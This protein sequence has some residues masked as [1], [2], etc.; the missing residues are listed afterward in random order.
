[1]CLPRKELPELG[2]LREVF[3]YHVGAGLLYWKKRPHP[4]AR[5]IKSG[6]IAGT[7]GNSNGYVC[8]TLDKQ[9]YVAH[10][11]ENNYNKTPISIH[12]GIC[13]YKS[14]KKWHVRYRKKHIGYFKEFSEAEE[15][16]SVIKNAS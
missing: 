7:K 5:S 10:R 9:L 4:N 2:R 11:S 14:S 12:P 15:A 6:S 1:M 3:S 16:L 13:W 8:I